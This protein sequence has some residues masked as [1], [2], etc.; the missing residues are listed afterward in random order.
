MKN[1]A[2]DDG[3]AVQLDT[4]CA[5]GP[6]NHSADCQLLRDDVAF[7]F[8]AFGYQNGQRQE[9]ALNLAP[10]PAP[11]AILPAIVVPRLMV[12]TWS[13]DTGSA[14]FMAA[15]CCGCCSVEGS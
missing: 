14:D 1:I 11:S 5:D 15:G 4:V 12:E 3:G 8:C 2:F 7:H 10:I 13:A 9:L 6:L